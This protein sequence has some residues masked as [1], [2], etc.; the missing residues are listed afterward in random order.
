MDSSSQKFKNIFKKKFSKKREADFNVDRKLVFSLGGSKIPNV[1]QLK[2]IGRYLNKKE[3][4]IIRASFVVIF[5]SLFFLGNNFYKKHL[6]IVPLREGEYKEALVGY[7]KYINPLYSM[8]SDVDN[9]IASLVYSSLFRRNKQNILENDLVEKY[10]ISE[11][12]KVYTFKIRNNAR[13]HN[14]DELTVD[15]IVFTF[16]LIKDKNIKSPLR[17]LFT[18]TVIEKIDEDEFKFILTESYAPFLSHLTFGILPKVIWEH[19]PSEAILLAELNIKPVGSGPFKFDKFA[20]DKFGNIK[21]YYL[22]VNDDYY[23]NEPYINLEFKF[24]S[25]FEEAIS[26]LN[27]NE[28]NGISYLPRYLQADIT[29][30]KTYF[31]HKLTLPQAVSLY[32]NLTSN[33]LMSN[34]KIRQALAFSV[35]KDEIVNSIFPGEVYKLEGPIMQDSFA[36]NADIKKYDFSL[37]ESLKKLAEEKWELTE[38]KQEDLAVIEGEDSAEKDK[39]RA[40]GPGKW[41]KK[42]GNFFA[43]KLIAVESDENIKVTDA[44]KSNWKKI[45]VNVNVEFVEQSKLAEQLEKKNYDVVLYS[46]MLGADPDPFF[47]WHSSQVSNLN[48][49]GFTDGEVDT[50]LEDGR[51]VLNEDQRKEKYVKFQEILMEELPA[52]FLYSKTYTYIQANIVKGFSL[53]KIYTPSDRFLNINEWYL[54]T[55][56]KMIW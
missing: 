37:E 24:F 2:Y 18:S 12:E 13:W 56:K 30:P 50:L 33:S 4:W 34:G 28:V 5:T 21:E 55:G 8:V 31:Y 20:K 1:K 3:L 36:Y 17:N 23:G 27:N 44:I 40:V 41:L 51:K 49:S 19:V 38:V 29:T 52:I 14:G 54:K 16:G 47:Y 42:D 22:T 46:Q 10:S 53:E 25:S 48:I 11:D 15:D 35:N 9:D 45:G 6:E 32:F 39:M 7:P 26:A 43:I